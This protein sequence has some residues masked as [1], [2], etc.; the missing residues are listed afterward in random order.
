[1]PAIKKIV[2]H[3]AGALGAMY[4]AQFYDAGGFEVYFLAG[5]TRYE[6][7]K[8]E[9]VVV[10]RRPYAIPVI[11]P[12]QVSAP[13]DLVLVALKHHHLAQTV[14]DLAAVVGPETV[15]LSVMNG[16]DSEA[17]IADVVGMDKVLYCIAV[18]MDALRDGNRV[19]YHNP[20]R[21]RFGEARNDNLS[22]AV[23]R[24]AAALDTAGIL[25]DTPVDMLRWLWWKFMVNVGVNQASAVMRAPFGVF[26]AQPEAQALMEDLMCE[27]VSLAEVEGVDLHL[28]DIQDWYPFLNAL[29]PEGKTSMLQDIQAGRMTEVAV[30]G[31]KVVELGELHNLPT[32]VNRTVVQIIRVLEGK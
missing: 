14:V 4:A 2:V 23:R 30:F 16:I 28:A 27:V 15:L 20:G 24:V 26:Q 7:L 32:P 5:G 8:A 29:S 1:M 18:G 6:R 31:C 17:I 10:N 25:H 13:A 9:G 12:D 21:L 22:P 19:D 11:H 3:G